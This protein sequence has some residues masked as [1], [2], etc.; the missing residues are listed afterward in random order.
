[1]LLSLDRHPAD[2]LPE[3]NQPADLPLAW[4]KSHGR[5]RVFYTALGHREDVWQNP[6]YQ[7]HVLGGVLWTL[8]CGRRRSRVLGHGWSP[9]RSPWVCGHARP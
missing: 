3:Q 7:Q 2:G 8:G 6:L 9:G 5:G 4:A 1:M